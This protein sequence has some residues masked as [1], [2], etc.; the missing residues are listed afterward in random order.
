MSDGQQQVELEKAIKKVNFLSE[1]LLEHITSFDAKIE[2]VMAEID[3]VVEQKVEQR[4]K[5]LGHG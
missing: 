5:E 2:E 4:L 3:E 1:V